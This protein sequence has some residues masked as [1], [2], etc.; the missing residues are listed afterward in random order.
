MPTALGRYIISI[1]PLSTEI[2]PYRI[3]IR[4]TKTSNYFRKN[5][6]SAPSTFIFLD[7]IIAP[8]NYMRTQLD[9]EIKLYTK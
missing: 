7:T 1:Y 9:A 8:Y 5:K 6:K 3:I 2:L 4:L